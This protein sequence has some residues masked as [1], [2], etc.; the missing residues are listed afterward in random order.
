M[1]LE[2]HSLRITT[3][4]ACGTF[5]AFGMDDGF[6]DKPHFM[7][8]TILSSIRFTML[9]D[10]VYSSHF[11]YKNTEAASSL[12]SK[13]PETVFTFLRYSSIYRDTQRRITNLLL[14][15]GLDCGLHLSH[16]HCNDFIRQFV[17]VF[18]L[19]I[20]YTTRTRKPVIL[21]HVVSQRLQE[22]CGL[23]EV[24]SLLS[25]QVILPILPATQLHSARSAFFPFG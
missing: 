1:S 22:H 12:A 16:G 23:D 15:I 19:P 8:S 13:E 3:L 5:P 21:V 20:S 10:W 2:K 9:N 17:E 11:K 14:H 7:P 18:L 4:Y 6:T 24:K 25:Y